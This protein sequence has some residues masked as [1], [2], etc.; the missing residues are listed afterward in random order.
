VS[1][2]P[3]RYGVKMGSLPSFATHCTNGRNVEI[4]PFAVHVS[5][6]S[7][8][9]NAAGHVSTETDEWTLGSVGR[10]VG[11]NRKLGKISTGSHNM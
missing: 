5:D 4:Q 6:V 11:F 7:V 9:D 10:F 8:A 1:G 3:V 2:K